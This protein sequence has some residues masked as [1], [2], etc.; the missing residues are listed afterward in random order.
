MLTAV[1]DYKKLASEYPNIVDPT[2][3][4]A[5]KA[6][7]DKKLSDLQAMLTQYYTTVTS[8]ITAL[9]VV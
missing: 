7:L 5:Y 4:E 1:A 2:L 6:V 3:K 9:Q 8:S